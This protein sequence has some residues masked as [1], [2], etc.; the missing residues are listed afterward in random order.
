MQGHCCRVAAGPTRGS[1]AAPR[2]NAPLI[3]SQTIPGRPLRP[4]AGCRVALWLPS[5]P[6]EQPSRVMAR[7]RRRRERRW[8]SGGSPSPTTAAAFNVQRAR[9]RSPDDSDHVA[10]G[11]ERAQSPACPVTVTAGPGPDSRPPATRNH[12]ARAARLLSVPV[13][14]TRRSAERPGPNRSEPSTPPCR[15]QSW[16]RFKFKFPARLRVRRPGSAG[17]DP[18]VRVS[19]RRAVSR[20]SGRDT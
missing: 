16:S 5:R 18:D 2:M 9:Q 19:R 14:R 4:V 8:A 1:V 10:R 6:D 11:R 7:G 15:A 13:T 17:A 12:A 3:C 20:H